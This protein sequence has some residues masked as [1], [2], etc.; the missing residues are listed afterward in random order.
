MTSD[1]TASG[2][3]SDLDSVLSQVADLLASLPPADWR[4]QS[5]DTEWTVRDVAGHLIWRLGSPAGAMVKDGVRAVVGDGVKP[6]DLIDA[7]SRKAAEAEPDQIVANLR[8]IAAEKAA[9]QGRTGVTELAE[10]IVHGYDLAVPLGRHLD[11]RPEATK[12]VADA[13][14][15]LLTLPLSAVVKERTLAATDA[16]WSVGS[17]PAI[18]GTAQGVLLYLY[19]RSPLPAS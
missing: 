13:R 3:A 1:T 14:M 11:I 15:L 10:A 2:W 17:G 8:A 12:A 6:A 4:T 19:G 5:L 7:M 18:K 9:G 16:G